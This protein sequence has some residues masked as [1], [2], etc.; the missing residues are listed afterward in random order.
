MQAIVEILNATRYY[1]LL[2]GCVVVLY[3]VVREILI[4]FIE[5]MK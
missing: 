5:E 2:A 4:N 3:L 1:W